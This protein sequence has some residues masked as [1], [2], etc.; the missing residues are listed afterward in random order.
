[1]EYFLQGGEGGITIPIESFVFV[2]QCLFFT[3]VFGKVGKDVGCF[4]VFLGVVPLF[5]LMAPL[6]FFGVVPIFLLG[7]FLAFPGVVP[8]CFPGGSRIC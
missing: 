4:L 2:F 1:M 8:L 6:T 3:L 7:V 5:S